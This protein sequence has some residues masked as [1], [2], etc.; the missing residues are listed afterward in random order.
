MC[1]MSATANLRR[2]HDAAGLIVAEIQA[3]VAEMGATPPAGDAFRM[4]ILLA[5][6]VGTL[7]IHFA[8]EDRFLYPSLMATGR[9]ETAAIARRFFD[10]MSELA[11]QLTAFVEKWRSLTEIAANW[12]AYRAEQHGVFAALADRI[13]RENDQLYPL[14]DDLAAMPSVQTAA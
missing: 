11:P 6:L 3:K 8:Q 7:R 4:T 2:Q 1:P 5:K 14:E 9:N 10:E 12:S 13:E